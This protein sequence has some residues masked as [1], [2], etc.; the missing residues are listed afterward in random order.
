MFFS[1]YQ[2]NSEVIITENGDLGRNAADHFAD[3]K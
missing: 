1:L 3:E 2:Q